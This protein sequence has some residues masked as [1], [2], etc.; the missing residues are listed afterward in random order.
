MANIILNIP[1]KNKLNL[2][3]SLNAA[4]AAAIIMLA[5][6]YVYFISYPQFKE[7][8]NPSI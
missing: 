1:R 3:E 7:L 5:F 6:Y 4:T 2:P 8:K